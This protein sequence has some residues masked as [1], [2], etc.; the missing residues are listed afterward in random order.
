[1]TAVQLDV[2]TLYLKDLSVF[3]CTYQDDSIFKNLIGYI[4]RNEIK[5]LVA[6]TFSLI[7]IVVAQQEFLQKRHLGKLVLLP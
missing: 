4:E 7:D 3:G 6:G 2:R 1:M 5:P